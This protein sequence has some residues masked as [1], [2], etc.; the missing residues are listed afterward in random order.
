MAKKQK[1]KIKCVIH[2]ADIHIR[3]FQRLEEYNEQLNR[4]IAKCREITE[5]LSKEEV[6]ILIAGDLLHNKNQISAEQIAFASTFIRELETIGLVRI[7]SGNHD[8]VVDNST[9]MDAMTAL[10]Q[11]AGFE[12]SIFMDS[13]LGYES[14]ILVD[15]NITWALYSI[16]DGFRK[17]DI[18]NAKEANPDNKIIGLFHGTVVGST[19]DNGTVMDSGVDGGLF[20]GCDYV[21]AGDIHKRQELKRGDTL[22][23]YPGSLIQ[24]TFGET[25]TKHG[26]AVWD[27]ENDTHDF[28]DLDSDYNLYKF[29]IKSVEDIKEDKETLMNY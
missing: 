7:I 28:I 18:E 4:F 29:E 2:C 20:E 10:F 14:G 21:M 17:P 23:V 8:L 26:F 3:L 1:T 27:I 16:F 13:Y 22:I 15:N 12:N 25:V 6:R 5:G 9:R 19:L 24:Q 11:T